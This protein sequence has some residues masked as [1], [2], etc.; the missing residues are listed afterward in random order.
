[1]TAPPG[2]A[3]LES[4]I[5]LGP[6]T[7][8]FGIFVGGRATRLGGAIKG[9]L[10]VPDTGEPIVVRLAALARAAHSDADVRLVGAG[11]AYA[12][13]GLDVLADSPRAAGPLGGLIALLEHAS[14]RG[15]RAA[16]ALAGDMPALTLQLLDRLLRHA[17]DADA[18]A[19]HFDA[20]WQPLFA[21]YRP[22]PALAAV[23][24]CLAENQLALHRVLWALGAGTVKLPLSSVEAHA[25]RDWDEPGDI[26]R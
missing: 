16:V 19:P 3:P 24:R 15:A 25:L 13:V 9:L 12:G 5:S 4:M 6:T 8:V 18:V 17:P 11:D 1:M 21:R 2:D 26:P 20:K 7:I 22:A 23:A 10:P 14:E